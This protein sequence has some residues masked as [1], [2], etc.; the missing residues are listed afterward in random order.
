MFMIIIAGLIA[1]S[2]I[3]IDS[4]PD[5]DVPF[6]VVTIIHE[7]ISPE[8]SE[9]MLIMPLET[10]MR[11]VEGIKEMMGFASEGA[12]TL[13]LEFHADQDLN[14]ALM[15]V[16]EATDRAKAEIPST[17]EE[18]IVQEASMRDWPILQVNIVGDV[19]ERMLYNIALDLRQSIETIPE[20]L[21]ADLM[22]DREELLEA[23]IDPNALE[24]F[25]ISSEEL[26]NTIVRN[27]RLIPAGALDTGQGRFSI[28]VPSIIEDARDVFQIPVKTV[29]DTV[30]TIGDVA[31]VRR[32]F[33]DRE[34][35]ARVNG[36][37]SITLGLNKRSTANMLSAIE[38]AKEKVE[39]YRPQLPAKVDVFYSSDQAPFARSQVTELQGNIFTALGLVMVVVVAAMGFRSGVI[40][41]IG[42]PVSFLF[43]LI[44]IYSLGYTFN[45]MVMFGMLLGLGML[46][47]GA[48]VVTE[49]ADR[50]MIEGHKPREAYILASRRMFWPVVASTATTLAAF[51]PLM[52]WPGIDGQFMRYLPV[53][54]FT[55]LS[56]SLLYALVFGPVLG[57]I[58]GKAGSRDAKS[59]ETLKQLEHGDPTTLN[60]VTGWYARLLSVAARY[61]IVTMLLTVGV[62]IG[63]FMA[64]GKFGSGVI[65]FSEAEAQ[66]ANVSVRAR[67]NLS[68]AEI[69][70]LVYEVEKEILEVAGIKSVNSSTKIPGTPSR[71]GASDQI[72]SIFLELYEEN[73]RNMSG[74]DIFEAIRA[75]T[76]NL[77]GIEIEIE[78]D[79]FGPPQGRPISIQLSA[80]DRTLIEPAIT[81]L[82]ERMES[83]AEIRD[84]SDTRPL[85]GIEWKLTV[86]KAQASI[87]GA[88]VSQVGIA[89]QLVTNGVKVGEYRPDRA[90]DGV[91]IRVRY[92]YEYR[93]VQAMDDLRIATRQGL[94]PISNFV[95]REST[96]NVDTLRRID[97]VPIGQIRADVVPGVLPDTK[98]GELE[99]WISE[100]V[101][102]PGLTIEFRGANEDA[103]NSMA[104]VSVAFGLSLLLMFVLLV[105]QF[106]RFYQSFLILFAVVLSTAG[107]FLGLLITGNPFSAILTGIGVVS[108]AG[109]VV[110][111][112]IVLI[113]TYNHLREE[114][115][116]LDY[117]SLIVRTGA[118]RLR[119]VLLTTITTVCGLL[120]LASNLSVDIVNR[121]FIYGGMMSS[122]W[123]PLS[124][125]I[126][127]GLT[128][129]TLLTLVC[130]PAMLALPEQIK[131]LYRKGKA[132]VR[133]DVTPSTLIEPHT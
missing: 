68:S 101:W 38:K 97:G 107:V 115:P 64:Y 82:V 126:V 51:L 80:Y 66:Y 95:T 76:D 20:I 43:S 84:I 59:Q 23:I 106:N 7:G 75:R 103:A 89:V 37:R 131:G 79:E 47:D 35:F 41:G 108:L 128:F 56:G 10:E 22:G 105:T 90:D 48:I 45:F 13:M 11:D 55:V 61:S 49:Y 24:A 99:D 116:D 57:S 130:T 50:K 1:R 67:G 30:V 133:T 81:R 123:V 2:A 54:V 4:D 36:Q 93:G 132:K 114:H 58:F 39:A 121:E 5:V 53:T 26:I 29:G 92:P 88:D 85:P 31:T 34:S 111:N 21:S 42:I 27:N 65:Y 14:K 62:L 104:F 32:T 74:T 6:F 52:F 100:Q 91:D 86:D 110:N 83:D 19:P 98:V 3:P 8:D 70:D 102:P 16:R 112:N 33:K 73:E 109:I 12:A 25:A 71:N 127:S 120:P 124:Q 125:A 17:A 122:M 15:D 9:R 78:A 119:P 69:N 87:F 63:T 117:L 129:S 72:G 60:S 46:I 18:P 96:P 40:V 44:F 113:D 94:V 77:A 118:Q 28:K